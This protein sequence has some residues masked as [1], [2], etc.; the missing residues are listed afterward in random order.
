MSL[1]SQV[2]SEYKIKVF[3]S[4]LS[5]LLG[6]ILQTEELQVLGSELTVVVRKI[7]ANETFSKAQNTVILLAETGEGQGKWENNK[8]IGKRGALPEEKRHFKV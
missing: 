6:L 1:S 7:G 2:C 8:R 5:S 3:S 4:I